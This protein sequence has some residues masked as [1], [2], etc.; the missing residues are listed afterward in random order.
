MQQRNSRLVSPPVKTGK[1]KKTPY[2]VIEPYIFLLPAL[3]IFGIFLYYPFIRTIYL[4]FFL[5][6][7]MGLPKVFYGV[8]NYVK[9]FKDPVF[10]DSL[11]ITF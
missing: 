11:K 5:T 9:L 8:Q 4:S 2:E 10:W 6:D 7:K 3:V 1:M